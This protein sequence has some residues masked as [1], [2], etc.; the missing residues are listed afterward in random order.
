[1]SLKREKRINIAGM[2]LSIYLDANR[3]VRLRESLPGRYLVRPTLRFLERLGRSGQSNGANQGMP[4]AAAQA[5]QTASEPPDDRVAT[6]EWYQSIELPE[7]YV[8]PGYVD[9]RGQVGH[10]GLPDDMSGTRALDVATYDGFWAF[11]MERRGA[12]VVAID[13]ETMAECD[14]PRRYQEY[15]KEHASKVKTGEG[16]RL[17]HELLESKVERKI[18]NVYDLGPESI[19]SFDF[20]FISDVLLHLRDPA[21]AIEKVCSVVRPGGLTIVAEPYSPSLELFN[22]PLSQFGYAEAVGWWQHSPATLGA[23]MWAAGYD[24]I[25]EVSRFT[26]NSKAEVPIEKIVLKGR[27]PMEETND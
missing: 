6:T 25:E 23:M 10:Y 22:E 4:V 1:M 26:L 2:Q 12:E 17:A 21:L 8:T 19:G 18:V 15:A 11:E 3:F 13:I 16:F 27:V 5:F 24:S 9:H 7:G 14:Y 20:A